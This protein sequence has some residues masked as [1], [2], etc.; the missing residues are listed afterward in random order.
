MPTWRGI[1]LQIPA[2]KMTRSIAKVLQ[3]EGFIAEIKKQEKG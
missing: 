1:K 2:T 3:E